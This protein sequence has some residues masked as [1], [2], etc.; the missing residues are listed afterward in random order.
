MS[1]EKLE[2]VQALLEEKIAAHRAAGGRVRNAKMADRFGGA[3]GLYYMPPPGT[4][5]LIGVLGIRH[6]IPRAAVEALGV[7]V[8]EAHFLEAGFEG[9]DRKA[10]TE[11]QG[12]SNEEL[13]SE[14]Y[15]VL[16][17]AIGQRLEDEEARAQNQE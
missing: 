2:Q 9:W 17:R 14:P 6:P 3:A 15:Y 12:M 11:T 13:F 7:T 16:G 5:C 8:L 1:I 4:V 10:F